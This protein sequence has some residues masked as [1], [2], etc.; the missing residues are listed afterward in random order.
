[1][2]QA[3]EQI[4]RRWRDRNAVD[5]A[6][7]ADGETGSRPVRGGQGGL[8]L[9]GKAGGGI[10]PRDDEAAAGIADGEPRRFRGDDRSGGMG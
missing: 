9:Q 10:W 5:R 7:G 4:P 3:K 8:L 1:M 6:I 2:T